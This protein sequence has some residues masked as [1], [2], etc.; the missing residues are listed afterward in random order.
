[1]IISDSYRSLIEQCWA[2]DPSDRL[3]FSEIVDK[4]KSKPGFITDTID[5][6]KFLDYVDSID[7]Y[8]ISFN[9]YKPI[10]SVK[11][12][13]WFNVED[14]DSLIETRIKDFNKRFKICLTGKICTGKSSIIRQ[15]RFGRFPE[16]HMCSLPI[17]Y[18]IHYNHFEVEV[19]D[20]CGDIDW[21]GMNST[22]LRDS[23]AILW[24]CSYD[25]IYECFN[26][27]WR[28]AIIKFVPK[29]IFFLVINKAD[30]K[31]DCKLIY[32]EDIDLIMS[33]PLFLDWYSISANDHDQVVNLF[34][35][36]MYRLIERIP[37][38]H[39]EVTKSKCQI[40]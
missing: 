4:L 10:L 32:D 11:D 38:I 21:F 26:S 19:W 9:E 3:S 31:E 5:E 34:N 14:I 23:D 39:D 28:E 40:Q 18:M 1:M 17:E 36:I 35:S 15:I 16:P 12:K 33:D 24:V 8:K 22:V 25:S 6:N 7:E 30:I 37:P 20:L 27:F 13:K 29:A 2:Q